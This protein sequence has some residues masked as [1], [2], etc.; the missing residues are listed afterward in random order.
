MGLEL[1]QGLPESLDK[2]WGEVQ[3]ARS[4]VF[5]H[6]GQV[7][8]SQN[9]AWVSLHTLEPRILQLLGIDRVPVEDFETR[10]GWLPYLEAARKAASELASLYQRKVAFV[11]RLPEN[12]EGVE[13]G[14]AIRRIGGGAGFD[15]DS[16]LTLL[17]GPQASSQALVGDVDSGQDLLG[18]VPV[19]E[20][21]AF[22][23]GF[24][25]QLE[26]GL[27]KQK[28]L[29]AQNTPRARALDDYLDLMSASLGSKDIVV[30]RLPLFLV[31]VEL[32]SNHAEFE[33]HDFLMTW[34]NVVLESREGI[35]RAEG[36]S[37]LLQSG[38]ERS[39]K[40]FRDAGYQLDLIPPLVRSVI[41]NG[42]Y[43]CASQHLRSFQ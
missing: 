36:F 31:P 13:L 28:L 24:R 20:L 1:I 35:R 17:E 23:K 5:F 15:L 29:D 41:L 38:D 26:A 21:E 11:H 12:E 32:L 3:W 25:V 6:N 40:I 39:Q 8:L 4:P 19:A 2:A 34:N 22:G 10:S 9:Q 43:R 7:L 42:G 16:L 27:L 33:H 37:S 18:S 14:N 30:R